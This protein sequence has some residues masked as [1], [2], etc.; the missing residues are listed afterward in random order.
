MASAIPD[1]I[2][3]IPVSG[4]KPA[5]FII[6]PEK[7]GLRTLATSGNV[8]VGSLDYPIS[9]KPIFLSSKPLRRAEYVSTGFSSNISLYL[10]TGLIFIPILYE[11]QC[12]KAIS[13]NSRPNLTLFSALPPYLSVL[14]FVLD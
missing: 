3:L 7:K 6:T 2:L 10:P 5:L 8:D 1:L 14:L 12:F 4:V 13:I 11:S 9:T